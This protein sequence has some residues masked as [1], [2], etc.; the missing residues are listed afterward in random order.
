MDEGRLTSLRAALV[1]TEMLAHLAEQVGVDQAL[2]LG[3]GEEESGGRRRLAN[4][5]GAFEAILGA[6]YLDQGLTAVRAYIEPLFEPLAHEIVADELD[7]DPKSQLQVLAQSYYGATPYYR[8]VRAE[9]PD[10]AKHFTVEV[11]VRDRVIGRGAG[12]SKQVAAMTAARS[13]LANIEAERL[14]AAIA[15]DEA[16]RAVQDGAEAGAEGEARLNGGSGETQGEEG[17]LG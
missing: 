3:R 16:E 5:C 17:E 6:L 14:A 4:L 1:R 15:A 7:R 11:Y 8:T 10:H 2:L 9:G 13:A 12:R